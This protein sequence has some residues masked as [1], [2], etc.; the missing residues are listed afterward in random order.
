MMMIIF[1][2]HMLV[3]LRQRCSTAAPQ[4]LC[5]CV[6]VPSVCWAASHLYQLL[7]TIAHTHTHTCCTH[8][9]S[10]TG[11]LQAWR[12]L[13]MLNMSVN[14]T[15]PCWKR[16]KTCCDYYS[17]LINLSGNK[18]KE[19]MTLIVY[20]CSVSANIELCDGWVNKMSG[21]S[22]TWSTSFEI[23]QKKNL[24]SPNDSL[25]NFILIYC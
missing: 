6:C 9:R 13:L 16:L 8:R 5:V 21:C 19:L 4:L 12:M 20:E 14:V 7:L 17:L 15:W 25:I 22:K 10:H 3:R 2:T 18:F 23:K 24:M 1:C 11:L